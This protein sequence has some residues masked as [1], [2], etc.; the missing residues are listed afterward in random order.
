MEPKDAREGT[1]LVGSFSASFVNMCYPWSVL[2]VVS[3]VVIVPNA[4]RSGHEPVHLQPFRPK[5][6]SAEWCASG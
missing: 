3:M 1:L 2:M 6:V 5:Q 4:V